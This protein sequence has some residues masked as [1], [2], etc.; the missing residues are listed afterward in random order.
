MYLTAI[1]LTA[2]LLPLQTIAYLT[3]NQSQE[4]VVDV[5]ALITTGRII[6]R[7]LLAIQ[8]AQQRISYEFP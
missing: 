5:H 1:G 2:G 8:Q 6:H 3:V 7:P 4:G